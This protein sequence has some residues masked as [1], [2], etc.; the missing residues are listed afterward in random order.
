MNE[1]EPF[2][3]GAA[4]TLLDH[5]RGTWSVE[6][7]LQDHAS[8]LTGVFTGTA[9]FAADDGGLRHRER[10]S[11]AWAGTAPT[12]ATRELLWRATVSVHSAEVFFPDGRFFHGLDLSD[13]QDQPEHPCS[14]DHYRG[15]FVLQDR[16]HWRYTWRVSG[17]AKDLTLATHLT[18]VT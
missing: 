9:T 16:A 11:L 8:G 15:S 1:S 12:I 10:G 6:R 7:T 5:L 2:R 14:P 17:P 13:G 4:A 18:R 3:L